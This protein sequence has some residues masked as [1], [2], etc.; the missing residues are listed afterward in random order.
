MIHMFLYVL[1]TWD[2]WLWVKVLYH[3][4]PNIKIAGTRMLNPN[5]S[6]ATLALSEK[7]GGRPL[8]SSEDEVR[9]LGTKILTMFLVM[10]FGQLARQTRFYGTISRQSFL[11][12]FGFGWLHFRILRRRTGGMVTQRWHGRNAETIVPEHGIQTAIL[13]EVQKEAATWLQ[14]A[15]CHLGRSKIREPGGQQAAVATPSRFLWTILNP[16]DV[17]GKGQERKHLKV[18]AP[19]W[20]LP[21]LKVGAQCF[22]TYSR[23]WVPMSPVPNQKFRPKG[24]HPLGKI[25]DWQFVWVKCELGRTSLEPKIR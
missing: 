6:I 4:V 8:Q 16:S 11:L 14:E 3:P 15:D 22:R 5:W 12:F 9:K 1:N 13:A 2:V 18:H 17:Q 25:Q 23:R 19:T 21:W 24:V 7:M 20:R 10:T